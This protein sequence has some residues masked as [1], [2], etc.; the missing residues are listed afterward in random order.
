MSR[1]HFAL[2]CHLGIATNELIS[3]SEL[4]MRK[5]TQTSSRKQLVLNQTEDSSKVQDDYPTIR[6]R[7]L[8][9][10][11]TSL[12]ELGSARTTTLEVQR[13]AEV[14][15]GALLHHF[16]S[17]AALLST[18]VEELV[19]RN[20]SAVLEA[21]VQLKEPEDGLT[22]AIKVLAETSSRPAYLAE[23]E[24]WAVARTDPDLRACLRQAER[25]ARKESERVLD[26]L[27]STLDDRPARTLVMSLTTEFLRGLALSSVLQN[28]PSRRHQMIADW[29]RSAAILINAL[30]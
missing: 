1:H 9:A 18:T 4:P 14:S 5:N 28:S 13:R 25:R 7:I 20:E 2:Q 26:A 15:R 12:I 29:T 10:A 11:V 17:H 22:R 6:E 24:L 30:D 3:L 16:P 21:L 27:F 23:M 8:D 19:R